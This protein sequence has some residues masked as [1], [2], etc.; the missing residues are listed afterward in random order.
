[1]LI[2]LLLSLLALAPFTLADVEFTSPSA[3]QT[4]AG[5]TVIKVAWKDS[6]TAPAISTLQTYQLFL[7]AGGNDEASFV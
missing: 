2:R 3:G 4:L 1:M 7:C 6:G 5:G